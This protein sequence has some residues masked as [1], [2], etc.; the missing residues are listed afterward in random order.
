MTCLQGL[1]TVQGKKDVKSGGD[2][3][4]VVFEFRKARKSKADGKYLRK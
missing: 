3:S 4:V 1:T 2:Y